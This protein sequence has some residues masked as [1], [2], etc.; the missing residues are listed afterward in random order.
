MLKLLCWCQY[1]RFSD[2]KMVFCEAEIKNLLGV[3]VIKWYSASRNLV[4]AKRG[5]QLLHKL[6]G[7]DLPSISSTYHARAIRRRLRL[8]RL[9]L[10]AYQARISIFTTEAD[11]LNEAPSLF[12]STITRGRGGDPWGGTRVGA[13]L[14][15]PDIVAAMHFVA[16][17]IGKISLIDEIAVLAN[18]ST[19]VKDAERAFLFAG[20]S[21]T[22]LLTLLGDG[23]GKADSKLIPY[24]EAY[25]A[26]PYPVYLLPCDSTGAKQLR[27]MSVPGY[28]QW[29]TRAT[30]QSEYMPP[31]ADVPD[32]DAIFRGAPF[33]MAA[34][35]DLRRID[36]AIEVAKRQGYPLISMAALEPQAKEVLYPRYV[37]TGKAKVFVW[38]QEIEEALFGERL[39]L[40]PAETAPFRNAKGEYVNA[41][42]IQTDRKSGRPAGTETGEMVRPA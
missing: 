13:L 3:G 14:H 10:T 33:V 40:R 17:G 8:S 27:L 18:H 2:L 38:T 26:S 42:L 7:E 23:S 9:M 1:I 39:K 11:E 32:W 30:L 31:P 5:N 16:P 41:P 22:E 4:L 25:R 28:R 19:A 21:Y 24:G 12:L 6:Y 29:F 15:L 20:K 35:M 34:D 36:R 37:N